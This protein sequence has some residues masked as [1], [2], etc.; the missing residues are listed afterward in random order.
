MMCRHPKTTVT[1]HTCREHTMTAKEY[2]NRYREL[3]DTVNSRFEELDRWKAIATKSS[4]PQRYENCGMNSDKVGKAAAEIADLQNN[5]D[6]DIIQLIEMREEIRKTITAVD[7]PR[8]RTLLERYYIC[9]NTWENIAEAFDC[10]VRTVYYW[11]HKALKK[12]EEI[13]KIS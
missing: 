11:H 12:V 6:E 9:R 4:P 1:E 7:N 5:I 3:D 2:L 8:L 13:L 10:S